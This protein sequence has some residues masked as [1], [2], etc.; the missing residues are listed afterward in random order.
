MSI[1]SFLLVLGCVWDEELPE[2]DFV[3]RLVIPKAAAT[4]EKVDGTGAAGETVFD[5]RFM[6]PIYVGAYS[7]MNFEA[8][9]YPHPAMGPVI[10]AGEPGNAFPYGGTTIGRL[11]FACYEAI[12]CRVVTGRFETYDALIDYF[13]NYIGSPI[14]DAE[15]ELVTSASVFQQECYELF[16]Y[17]SDAELAF[18]G[19]ERLDFEEEGDN[20]VAEFVLPHTLYKEGMSVWGWMDAPALTAAV[21]D[22]DGAFSTCDIEAGRPWDVYDEEFAQGRTQ[23]DL[24]N[25]PSNYIYGGDWVADGLTVVASEDAEI[26]VNINIQVSEGL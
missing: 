3:G 26:E 8:F 5:V 13:A 4:R 17:T 21:G 19:A 22:V 25:Y 20:L 2:R 12:K 15:G 9:S 18:I 10:D 23:L 6:G 1:L 16:D 14:V 7:G 24:M 11:D